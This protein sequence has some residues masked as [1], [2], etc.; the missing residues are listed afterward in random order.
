MMLVFFEGGK[1]EMVKT[2]RPRKYKGGATVMS[3]YL[4]E[5]LVSWARKEA[6]KRNLSLSEFV[7]LLLLREKEES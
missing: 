2:G 6:A 4:P 1:N 7:A 3:V 5:G